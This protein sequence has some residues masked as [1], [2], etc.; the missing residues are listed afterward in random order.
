MGLQWH[1]QI[2][3][4]NIV[5]GNAIRLSLKEQTDIENIN[6]RYVSCRQDTSVVTKIRRC[7]PNV[8]D[9]LSETITKLREDPE[10]VKHV[11]DMQKLSGSRSITKAPLLCQSTI[12]RRTAI[13][14]AKPKSLKLPFS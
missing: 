3:L 5:Y 4:Y 9:T 8:P 6:I 7:F 10:A 1:G 2:T 14:T 12:L 11:L 13:K